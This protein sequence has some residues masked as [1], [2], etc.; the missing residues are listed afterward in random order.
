MMTNGWYA[1]VPPDKRLTQGDLMFQ[2]PL[3]TWKSADVETVDATTLKGLTEAIE[4]DV[5]VLTQACDLEHDKVNN[6]LVCPHL[7]LSEYKNQWEEEMHKSSQNPTSKAW[8]SHCEDIREGFVWNMAI[9]EKCEYEIF[10]IEHRVVMF[11][12]VFTVPRHFVESLTKQRNE[13]RLQLLPPYREHLSQAF[14][15]F[16][17]RVG[18]PIPVTK[19]W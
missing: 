12:E 14:A 2:C 16:F 18:L 8:R 19:A 4:A 6:V 9:L 11:D 5:I 7:P 13:K 1:V 17:M 15:R 3:V 10:S